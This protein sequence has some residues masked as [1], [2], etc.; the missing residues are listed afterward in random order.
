MPRKRGYT[1]VRVDG[2]LQDIE[3]GMQLDRYKVHDIELVI[4][5][6]THEDKGTLRL[7]G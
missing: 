2:E 3:L 5:R 7:T 4:D 1:K 6:V